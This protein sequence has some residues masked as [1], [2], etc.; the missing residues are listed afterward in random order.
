MLG[1]LHGFT[2][3][4]QMRS[5]LEKEL[6]GAFPSA[7]PCIVRLDLRGALFQ[8]HVKD[9]VQNFSQKV[10]S[11]SAGKMP[12]HGRLLRTMRPS[13]QRL[14]S[15]AVHKTIKVESEVPDEAAF[16]GSLFSISAGAPVAVTKEKHHLPSVRVHFQGQRTV[17]CAPFLS[18]MEYMK[19]KKGSECP[20]LSEGNVKEYFHKM[21]A[22]AWKT[23]A[24]NKAVFT[25]KAGPS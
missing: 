18:V 2:L 7:E 8:T 22:E 12:S 16:L 23:L 14:I 17:A 6:K 11:T 15:D 20:P 24:A 1:G 5:L 9:A 3:A 10:A 19:E 25:G 4:V 21:D 13:E